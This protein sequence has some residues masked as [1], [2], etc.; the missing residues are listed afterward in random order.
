MFTLTPVHIPKMPALG[1][2]LE[3][4]VFDLYS[5]KLANANE[6]LGDPSDPA[7]RE[8][9]SFEKY[10]EQMAAFKQKFIYDNMR[11]IEDRKGL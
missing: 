4:P 7:W 3:Y 8:P 9:L 5:K 1:L 2:L 10:A 11:S 6:K